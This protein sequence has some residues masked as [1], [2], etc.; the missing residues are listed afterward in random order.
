MSE[1]AAQ[2]SPYAGLRSLARLHRS[3][4]VET[5]LVVPAT[6]AFALYIVWPLP[7][8]L[9]EWIFGYPGDSTGTIASSGR[10]RTST[11]S[12]SSGRTHIDFLGAP[13]GY[14]EDSSVN[15]TV[16]M[17][18]SSLHTC[19]RSSATRS[20][21]TTSSS[22]RASRCRVPRCTGLSGTWAG[23][24]VA[25]V[26]RRRL[27]G[28]SVAPREGAG[29]RHATCTSRAF[30]SSCWRSWPGERARLAAWAARRRGVC[31]HLADR[32][33]LRA[34]SRRSPS[35]C[36]ARDRDRSYP[37]SGPE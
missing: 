21:R 36:S 4:V 5:V 3:A 14:E 31:L 13:F 27:H 25:G 37:R 10:W 30:R 19:W 35:R 15:L 8:H 24:L 20:P 16:A 23:W 17:H 7:Y 29:T 32:R 6:L 2:A 28:V 12:T 9:G 18:H 33:L 34:W 11:G 26:E 22:S 1:H